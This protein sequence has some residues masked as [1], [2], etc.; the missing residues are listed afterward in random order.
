VGLTASVFSDAQFRGYSLSEG[1]PAG[2]LDFA[3]DDSSGLY[4]DVSASGVLR[5]GGHPAP[6]GLQL[7]GGYAQR[8]PSGTIIDLGLVHSNYA[9]YA[10]SNS[11]A[12]YT[13]VYAGIARGGLSSRIFL[14]RHYFE[15]GLCTAYGEVNGTISP[16]PKWSLDG[17]AGMLVPLRTPADYGRY[18][19]QLDWRIGVSRELGRFSLH[20]AWS[21]GAPGRDYFNGRHHSRSALIVGASIVL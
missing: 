14:S 9:H 8:L 19:P 16:A 18:R 11:A 21:D 15:R 20:A 17:H 4:A 7:N 1:R 2:F 12:S 10:T 5:R 3:W 13:E 6:L